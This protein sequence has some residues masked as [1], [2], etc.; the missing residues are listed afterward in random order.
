MLSRRFPVSPAAAGGGPRQPSSPGL[1]ALRPTELT[2]RRAGE[3]RGHRLHVHQNMFAQETS[4]STMSAA[5]NRLAIC[6][7]KA[8]RRL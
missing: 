6:L 7:A 2:S 3:H 8:S 1:P 4:Q 5:R